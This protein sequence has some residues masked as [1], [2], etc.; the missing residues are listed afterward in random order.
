MI[1][2]YHHP[3]L[4]QHKVE[5]AHLPS[6]TLPPPQEAAVAI[7]T[8]M[9]KMNRTLWSVLMIIIVFLSFGQV[10][11]EWMKRKEIYE[12]KVGNIWSTAAS[13]FDTDEDNH[14]KNTSER[15]ERTMQDWHGILNNLLVAGERIEKNSKSIQW[16]PTCFKLITCVGSNN[17]E[18]WEHV[19]RDSP[20]HLTIHVVINKYRVDIYS[21]ILLSVCNLT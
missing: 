14:T 3:H 13:W 19:K 20:V 9:E 1:C 16:F 8:E 17:N 5:S 4:E 15:L 18:C 6:P 2:S 21:Y 10:N 7:E 11:Y 12:I